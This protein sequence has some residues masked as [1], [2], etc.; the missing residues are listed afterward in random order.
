MKLKFKEQ[1][2]QLDAVDA[3]VNC[4][5]GQGN[6][7]ST[8]TLE[9]MDKQVDKQIVIEEINNIEEDIG[10]KNKKDLF[11]IAG[12]NI[13]FG[14]IVLYLFFIIIGCIQQF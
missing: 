11:A 7:K 13:A 8:F 10:Y 4:F 1:Q 5:E 14:F 9:R 3:V 6:Q 12:K 2:F